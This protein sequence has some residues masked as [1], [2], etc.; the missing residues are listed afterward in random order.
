MAVSVAAV[1]RQVRNY[2]ERER[3]EGPSGIVGGTLACAPGAAYVAVQGVGVFEQG[4]VPEETDSGLFFALYPPADF[5]ALCGEISDYDDRHPAG[6]PRS[7]SFGA[8][9]YDRGEAAADGWE[10]AFGA[11]LQPYRRMFTEVD[12]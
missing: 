9:R 1:M 11:R 8:Y 6:A 2:F 10:A 3:Y 4:Q 7:E 5:L 12:A